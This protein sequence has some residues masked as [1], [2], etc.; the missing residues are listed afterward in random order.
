MKIGEWDNLGR[1][2][3]VLQ[4]QLGD[5]GAAELAAH[6][7]LNPENGRLRIYVATDIGLL[8]Y[9]Y[10][11]AGADPEGAWMLRGQLYRWPS[12]KGVRLQ[13]DAQIDDDSGEV[14][15]IWRL[16]AEDPKLELSADST[17][18]GEQAPAAMLAFARAC[19]QHAG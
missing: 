10:G 18:V 8:E 14:R 19:I 1:A 4:R 13:N 15:A 17:G 6:V 9:G 7:T 5:L 3:A 11:P 2:R 12:V 16:V